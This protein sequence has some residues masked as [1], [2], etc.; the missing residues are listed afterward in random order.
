MYIDLNKKIRLL[1]DQMEGLRENFDVIKSMQSEIHD[2]NSALQ[3][4]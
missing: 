2:L 4:Y 1:Q 3:V